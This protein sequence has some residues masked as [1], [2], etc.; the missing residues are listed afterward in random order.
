VAPSISQASITHEFDYIWAFSVLIH[1]SDERLGECLSYVSSHLKPLGVLYANVNLGE[2]KE[3]EAAWE[4]F[5]VVCRSL[6]FYRETAEMYG[7]NLE[8]AGQIPKLSLPGMF[9]MLRI[10]RRR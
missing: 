7:L 3:A 2:R 6:E 1:M 10:S 9:T 4:G 8:P 5:P